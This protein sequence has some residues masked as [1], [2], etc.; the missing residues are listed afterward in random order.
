MKVKKPT[1][2]Y[3]AAM[4]EI[5]RARYALGDRLYWL[6][7]NTHPAA[8]LARKA[9]HQADDI[10]ASIERYTLAAVRKMGRKTKAK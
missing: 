1:N 10:L 9:L 5:T 7:Q 4:S 3:E 2:E 6:S 8:V